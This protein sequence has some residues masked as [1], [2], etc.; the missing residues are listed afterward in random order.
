MPSDLS[1]VLVVPCSFSVVAALRA[2]NEARHARARIIAMAV[3][4]LT[5]PN[6]SAEPPNAREDAPPLRGCVSLQEFR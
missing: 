1:K 2:R 4:H 6:I 5:E 3:S